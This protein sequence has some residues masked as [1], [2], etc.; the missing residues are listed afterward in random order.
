[1]II[2]NYLGASFT[3]LNC[4]GGGSE[5]CSLL[6]AMGNPNMFARPLHPWGCQSGSDEG[7]DEGGLI[8]RPTAA[9][10]LFTLGNQIPF[11]KSACEIVSVVS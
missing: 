8:Y 9:N 11:F 2:T 5:S 10:I 3:E 6:L 1:M 7:Q 4:A